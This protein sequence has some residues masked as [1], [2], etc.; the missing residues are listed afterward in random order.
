[1]MTKGTA[2]ATAS[3]VVVFVVVADVPVVVNKTQTR[4]IGLDTVKTSVGFK[5]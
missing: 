3:D 4:P 2:T 5:V 1:M